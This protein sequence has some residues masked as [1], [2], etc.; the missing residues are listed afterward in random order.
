MK[1]YPKNYKDYDFLDK[2]N[3]TITDMKTIG[4]FFKT[5]WKSKL[6]ND[7]MVEAKKYMKN[8]YYANKIQKCWRNFIV[9]RFNLTHGPAMFKRQLCNNVDDFLTTEEMKDISYYFFISFR[10]NDGFIYGFNIISLYNLILKNNPVNP[11]NR[12]PFTKGFIHRINQRI[13]YNRIFKQTHHF[14][15]DE[16]P[17]QTVDSK[18]MALFQ[19]IDGLGNY[20]QHEWITNLD[21]IKLRRFILEL[22][23]IWNHRAQLANEIK[24]MI[25]PPNG[26]PF[27]NIP[28]QTINHNH[29]IDKEQLKHIVCEIISRLV[30]SAVSQD[31]QSLGAYYVLTALTL[32]SP[33]AAEAMPWLYYSVV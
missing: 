27:I 22:Y 23:D 7:I 9:N 14:I 26:T 2:N 28:I 20:T 4:K 33:D 16:I 17:V 19:K 18:L 13:I 32:V 10:D 3:Y 31:N 15:N 12:I 21:N 5:K 6:K 24:Y 8:S 1:E 25:C 11:Y 30:N 29:N